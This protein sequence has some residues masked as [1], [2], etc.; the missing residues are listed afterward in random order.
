VKGAVLTA[1]AAVAVVTG[2]RR[3]RNWGATP[4]EI[5]TPLPGDELVPEPADSTTRAVEIDAPAA[6]VWRW[7]VQIGQGRGGMYSYDRLENLIGLDIHSTDEIREEWQHLAVGD[8]VVLVR[9]GWGP[10]ADGYA[11]PVAR[12]EPGEA[13]VLLQAPPRHPWLAVWTFAIDPLDDTRCRLL[14]RSR[15]ARPASGALRVATAAMEPLTTV[16]TRRMLLGIK[17]RAERSWRARSA[18][19]GMTAA[20]S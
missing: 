9:P 11:L 19:A 2:L 4:G 16:M 1:G 12:I 10:A 3:A 7:L 20:T 14:S 15:A 6:E 18:D 17:E 13:I 5:T 8:E